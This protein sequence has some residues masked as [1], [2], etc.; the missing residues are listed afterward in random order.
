MTETPA[1]SAKDAGFGILFLGCLYPMNSFSHKPQ[2]PQSSRD[3]FVIFVT[4]WDIILY[5][6]VFPGPGI[7]AEKK[8]KKA[9]CISRKHITGIVHTQVNPAESNDLNKQY[10]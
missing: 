4:L 9:E 7:N 3:R 6:R 5:H 2:S 8:P 10:Q 1:R